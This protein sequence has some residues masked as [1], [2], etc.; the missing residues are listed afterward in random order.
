MRLDSCSFMDQV[1]EEKVLVA[2]LIRLVRLSLVL[3]W[4]C[5]GR[6]VRV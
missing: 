3:L 4:H 6:R 5:V 2:E 1:G